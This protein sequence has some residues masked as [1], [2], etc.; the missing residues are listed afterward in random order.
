MLKYFTLGTLVLASYVVSPTSAQTLNK[1]KE[2]SDNHNSSSNSSSSSS[3]GSSDSYGSNDTYYEGGGDNSYYENSYYEDDYS[4]QQQEGGE[5]YYVRVKKRVYKERELVTTWDLNFRQALD[6]RK[7]LITNIQFNRAQNHWFHSLRYNQFYEHRA[8]ETDSYST[9]EWQFL[10]FHTMTKPVSFALATGRM[11][12]SYSAKW[13]WE[14]L[15]QLEVRATPSISFKAEGRIALDKGITVR[16]E[17]TISSFLTIKKWAKN[18]AKVG[19]F[20]TSALYYEMVPVENI[21]V[22]AKIGFK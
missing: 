4:N 10:G 7:V 1:I 15:A 22:V 16:S 11:F 12:E 13:Y 20:F 6:N 3:S 9:F 21:G 2:A 18:E 8:K 17:G 5:E 14:H 19:I